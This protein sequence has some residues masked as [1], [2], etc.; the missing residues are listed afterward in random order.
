M[1]SLLRALFVVGVLAVAA[2]A[3]ASIGFDYSG[4][5]ACLKG[6]STTQI[7][8]VTND[9]AYSHAYLS[10]DN[11]TSHPVYPSTASGYL[12][13]PTTS[14]YTAAVPSVT[15]SNYKVYIE[16][17]DASHSVLS[18]A[19]S[20]AFS[21]DSSGPSAPVVGAPSK[22]TTTVDLAWN[23]SQITDAGCRD[24]SAGTYHI[25]RN[26][27]EIGQTGIGIYQDTGLSASTTYTY[28]IQADDGFHTGDSVDLVVTTDAAP[29]ATPP[30][31]ST[32]SAPSSGSGST[33]TP[34]TSATDTPAATTP[35]ITIPTTGSVTPTTDQDKAV[36]PTRQA[37]G[38]L[39]AST[40][41]SQP[42]WIIGVGLVLAIGVAVG[43]KVLAKRNKPIEPVVPPAI[44]APPATKED[45]L[46]L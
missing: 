34:S 23:V 26:G 22:S 19:L 29:A 15:A 44:A 41:L 12:G 7:K 25:F 20:T 33:A 46:K 40:M 4:T 28:K 16:S 42:W 14:P 11:G 9:G 13:H 8:W 2:P 43:G 3:S 30:P 45:E 21:I 1:K 35:T 39:S 5:S 38:G 32:P 31:A 36:T 27:V 18:T 17:H 37:S 10:L 6:G 24:M